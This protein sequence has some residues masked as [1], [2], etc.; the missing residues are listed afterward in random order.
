MA[1]MTSIWHGI[2]Q[3]VNIVDGCGISYKVALNSALQF[4][5][6]YDPNKNRKEA[7]V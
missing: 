2:L 3:V 1:Y 5:I 6:M 7:L 4:G